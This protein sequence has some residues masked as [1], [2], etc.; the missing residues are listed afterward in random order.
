MISPIVVYILP[1]IHNWILQWFNRYCLGL[2][3]ESQNEAKS[4]ALSAN[5]SCSPFS[6]S[7]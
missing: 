7:L 6:C 3:Y 4:Y 2:M 1:P 5:L